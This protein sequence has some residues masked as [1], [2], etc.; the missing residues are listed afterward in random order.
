MNLG[1]GDYVAGLLGGSVSFGAS[2]TPSTMTMSGN[3]VHGRPRHLQ[4][5]L[6]VDPSRGM[7][8]GT[9]TSVWTPAAT[10]YDRAANPMSTAPATES[11]AADRDF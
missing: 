9:G 5:D 8:G 6:L 11:G 3:V 7:A 1:R 10:P 2:G 4:L